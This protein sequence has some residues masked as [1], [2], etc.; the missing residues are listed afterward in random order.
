MACQIW[1]HR[2]AFL[3]H[4]IPP[5]S[6]TSRSF[7]KLSLVLYSWT[8]PNACAISTFANLL[9]FLT[10]FAA[11]KSS[12]LFNFFDFFNLP[13]IVAYFLPSI[14][15]ILY[16]PSLVA[17]KTLS[18]TPEPLFTSDIPRRYRSHCCRQILTS[19]E[20]ILAFLELR[21]PPTTRQHSNV[22]YAGSDWSM[23]YNHSIYNAQYD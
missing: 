12:T 9:T 19:R 1:W 4:S 10:F 22:G 21:I 11:C 20:E 13:T 23:V 6:T 5:C 7:T 16:Q 3:P 15:L 2:H 17:S 14:H 8:P 18:D